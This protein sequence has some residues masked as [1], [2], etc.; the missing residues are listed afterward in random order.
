MRIQF[1]EADVIVCDGAM[2]T[3]LQ[4]AGLPGPACPESWNTG[5]PAEIERIH[6][7]YVDAGARII[8]SNTFGANPVKLREYGLE[9][10]TF[11]LNSRGAAIARRAAGDRAL[12]AGSL[13]PTGALLRPLGNLSFQDF[14]DAFRI[15]AEGLAD[16]GADLFLV[17]TMMEL[18]ELK[19]AC[20]A[21]RDTDPSKPLVAQMTFGENGRTVMGSS[22]EIAASVLEALG[23][24]TIGANCST[25]P[26]SLL[27]VVRAM[28][29]VTARPLSALP[30]AGLPV[31]EDGRCVYRQ[32]PEEMAA[33]AAGFVEAGA[34]ILGGCCGTT[35]AHTAAL[36]AA[37]APLRWLPRKVPAGLAL[38][39]RKNRVVIG[40]KEVRAVP[41]PAEAP[42]P[43][44]LR[45][46]RRRVRA[47]GELLYLDVPYLAED[48]AGCEALLSGLHG[49]LDRP[50]VLSTRLGASLE[51][52]LRCN[53]GTALVADVTA[54]EVDNLARLAARCGAGLILS[55]GDAPD[56]EAEL[57]RMVRALPREGVLSGRIVLDTTALVASTGSPALPP[58]LAGRFPTL[59]K[60]EGI[61]PEIRARAH[62]G[63]CGPDILVAA[64]DGDA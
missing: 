35:P 3:M 62:A 17:E 53:P 59:W 51:P 31:L 21:V 61:A 5:E 50:L 43:A 36:A 23:A 26:E 25:G 37:A 41:A 20:L 40:E 58:E 38:C 45:E 46:W 14:Y 48:P 32:T 28:G 54:R 7:A 16:G 63:K 8:E 10:E 33:Y 27:E 24:D 13:G 9:E 22:P 6:R 18:S 55:P 2:G 44:L 29:R 56:P 19:A 12:V 15:Q 52:L 49:P 47:G 34:R 11:R 39:S 4:Q 30:N 60:Q 64:P 1:D 57:L 42:V